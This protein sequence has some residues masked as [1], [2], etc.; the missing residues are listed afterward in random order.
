M[1]PTR[2]GL[3]LAKDVFEVFAVD[4]N[5]HPVLKKR[6][7]RNKLLAFFAQLAPCMVAMEA[8]ASA[9]HWTRELRT[10]GH[11]VRLI[12]PRFVIPY[13]RGGKND[14]NDARAICE[15]AGRPDMRFVPVKSLEQQ[16]V[17]SVHRARSL[18]VEQRTALVNQLRGLLGEFGIAIARGHAAVRRRVPEVLENAHHNLPDLARETFA[19]LYVRLGELDHYLAQYDR[20]IRALAT[21]SPQARRLM[22]VPGFGPLSATAL[23]AT[24]GQGRDFHNGRQFSAWLGLTPRQYSSAGKTRR[25]RITKRGDRYLRTLLVHGARSIVAR[26]AGRTEPTNRWVNAVRER[27]GFNKAT[28]AL[29][30]KNARVVWA[31]LAHDQDF[32]A[33]PLANSGA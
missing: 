14:P 28:V 29:A 21:S 24:V 22:Q 26:A 18:L 7:T 9:H 12:D 27:R 11:E 5:D 4:A 17:L 33:P 8:C 31:M 19:D 25:G 30:A 13:R 1:K 10:L 2:I 16:A 6:L 20:R 15:A 3:D 23:L 32:R